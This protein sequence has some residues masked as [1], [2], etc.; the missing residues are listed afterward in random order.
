MVSAPAAVAADGAA[1]SAVP[2]GPGRTVRV[3]LWLRRR[4]DS[5]GAPVLMFAWAFAEALVWPIIP[6]ASLG[7]LALARP[8]RWWLLA[9]A[10]VAGSVAGGAAGW[11]ATAQGWSWPLPLTTANMHDAVR[12][13]LQQG[14]AGVA[15]QPLSGVPYKVFVVAA[16][17]AGIGWLEL[18]G[19]TLRYRGLRIVAT[20]A[21]AAGA[22]A[23][24][25]RRPRR[26][27]EPVH[28]AVSGGAVV[29][30][31]AGLVVLVRAWS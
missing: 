4:A 6:D 8:R 29:A 3:S 26:W 23:L 21:V 1:A 2:A 16:P 7:I 27:Q 5:R 14:A 30:L 19:A 20:A 9:A 18:A 15:H 13:W 12:G 22:G 11:W 28:A 25:W 31:F 17:D 24:L 10:A